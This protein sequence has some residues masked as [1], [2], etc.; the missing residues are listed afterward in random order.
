[1]TKAFKN[2]DVARI[3]RAWKYVQAMYLI[4]AFRLK[5]DEIVV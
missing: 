1:M 2:L 4:Q 5:H 3:Y